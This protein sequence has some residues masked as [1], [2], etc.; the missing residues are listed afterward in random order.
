MIYL[1]I[2]RHDSIHWVMQSMHCLSE[3]DNDLTEEEILRMISLCFI[4]NIDPMIAHR[5]SFKVM[6]LFREEPFTKFVVEAMIRDNDYAAE[7]LHS[8]ESYREEMN[9]YSSN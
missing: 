6:R 5:F 9:G 3:H 2:Y 1:A 7:S 8:L 4:D